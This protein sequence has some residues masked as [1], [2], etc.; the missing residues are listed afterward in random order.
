MPRFDGR[1]ETTAEEHWNKFCSFADN[2]NFEHSDVWMR[3][4]VQSLDG[5]VRKWFRELPPDS[6]DGIDALEE[7]FMK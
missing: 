7:A 2:Q 3:I 5:E 1:G 6:I 4:F